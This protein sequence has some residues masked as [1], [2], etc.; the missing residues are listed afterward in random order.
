MPMSIATLTIE[1]ASR[2][3]DRYDLRLTLRDGHT[4]TKR[5]PFAAGP[6]DETALRAQ[7]LDPI[8]Y[9]AALGAMLFSDHAALTAYRELRAAA[10]NRAAAAAFRLQLHLPDP[11]HG[12]R[13]EALVD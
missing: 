6:F 8:A 11:L 10:L 13:W 5:G 2:T 1:L 9:G 3:D 4:D 12:L 7:A